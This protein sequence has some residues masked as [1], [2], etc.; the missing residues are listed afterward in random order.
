V[1]G[2]DKTKETAVTMQEP[3]LGEIAV[4]R[5]GVNVPTFAHVLEHDIRNRGRLAVFR[6]VIDAENGDDTLPASAKFRKLVPLMVLLDL[7]IGIEPVRVT[8]E[9]IDLIVTVI[10]GKFLRTP[11]NFNFRAW[12]R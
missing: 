2:A 11:G 3:N 5:L 10:I 8:N 9:K 6:S 12:G 4:V 7:P 1:I